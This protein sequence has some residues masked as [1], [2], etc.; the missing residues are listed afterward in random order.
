MGYGD[1]G[2]ERA[3]AWGT[4]KIKGKIVVPSADVTLSFDKDELGLGYI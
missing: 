4:R 2:R 3:I 1:E